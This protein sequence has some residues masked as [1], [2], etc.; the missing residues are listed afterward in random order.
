MNGCFYNP[1]QWHHYAQE[2]Q[3]GGAYPV[4]IQCPYCM[5]IFDINISPNGSPGYTP[6][7]SG[8]YENIH[9]D[10]YQTE[11]GYYNIYPQ[12]ENIHP[13]YYN[14]S[15]YICPCENIHSPWDNNRM[16]ASNESPL[17]GE[18]SQ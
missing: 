6:V 4:R 12:T 1:G 2:H 5:N 16:F 18:E 15:G 10:A 9:P 7:N 17:P 11:Y 13:A 14:K 3:Y 8:Y